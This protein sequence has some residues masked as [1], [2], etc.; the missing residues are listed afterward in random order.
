MTSFAN[1]PSSFANYRVTVAA[2]PRPAGTL[3]FITLAAFERMF[4]CT[5]NALPQNVCVMGWVQSE[6]QWHCAP[7]NVSC[8]ASAGFTVS[9]PTLNLPAT[10]GAGN[11]TVTASSSAVGT[12][13]GTLTCTRDDGG[14]S[15]TFPLAFTF[16]AQPVVPTLSESGLWALMTLIAGFGLFAAF[17]R[18]A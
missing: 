4:A 11:V 3:R 2:S 9:P 1:Q 14:A 10:S 6:Q 8:T 17:R 16:T 12:V 15:F 7:G 13:S 5:V 18:R